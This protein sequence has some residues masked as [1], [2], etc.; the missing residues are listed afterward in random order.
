[1]MHIKRLVSATAIAVALLGSTSALV[2]TNACAAGGPLQPC[3]TA[4]KELVTARRHL[5]DAKAR[6][7]LAGQV[8]AQV[9]VLNAQKKVEQACR[10]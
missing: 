7:D 5:D 6:G 10:G 3:V 2:A 1:M 8:A 4:Q 9:E